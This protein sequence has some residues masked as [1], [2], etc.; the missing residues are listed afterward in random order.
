M[1]FRVLVVNQR[2]RAHILLVKALASPETGSTPG[3]L[4]L[5]PQ[6]KNKT[7]IE[8]EFA[9]TLCFVWGPSQTQG[10]LLAVLSAQGA[11][12]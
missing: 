6:N 11:G 8:V 10:L 9:F 4:Q 7:K 1:G 2:A 12:D 3:F 5:W